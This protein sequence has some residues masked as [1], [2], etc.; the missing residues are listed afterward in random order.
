MW[1]Y[2]VEMTLML[3]TPILIPLRPILIPLRAIATTGHHYGYWPVDRCPAPDVSVCWEVITQ[4]N[5]LLNKFPL[6]R[7]FASGLI[8]SSWPSATY[9]RRDFQCLFPQRPKYVA[10]ISVL[11]SPVPHIW[12]V[13][14]N[15]LL[16]SP[17]NSCRSP[18]SL[19]SPAPHICD[20]SQTPILTR[21]VW[22]ILNVVT[23]ILVVL[24]DYC[25]PWI[26]AA[27]ING[28]LLS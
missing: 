19:I 3:S 18:A 6:K 14:N 10:L 25:L 4:V 20:A 26:V 22:K 16:P 5:S 28:P 24:P 7:K 17:P 2:W 23:K 1:Q 9:M 15:S 27:E 13:T 8:N 11:I 12:G 21:I